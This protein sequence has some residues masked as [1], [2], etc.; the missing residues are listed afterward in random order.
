MN[1]DNEQRE[2]ML[3]F[4]KRLGIRDMQKYFDKYRDELVE[5]GN[6][7]PNY[8]RASF[9]KKGLYEKAIFDQADISQGYGYKLISGEKKTGQR[10]VILR[11]CFAMKMSL[12]EFQDALCYSGFA[13]LCPNIR[14][15]AVLIVAICNR[16]YDILLVNEELR[17][18][19][20]EEIKFSSI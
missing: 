19:G 15:D 18:Y 17:K 9:R 4:L 20:L 5:N 12:E 16:E 8:M 7:F 10:D 13:G 1:Y 11:L 6:P 14:R 2:K 3:A